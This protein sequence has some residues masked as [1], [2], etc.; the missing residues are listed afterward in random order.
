MKK[1]ILESIIISLFVF[2]VKTYTE[3]FIYLKQTNNY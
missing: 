2:P 3:I 1:P